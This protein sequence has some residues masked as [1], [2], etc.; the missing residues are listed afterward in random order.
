MSLP[1]PDSPDEANDQL[2][3]CLEAFIQ[4]WEDDCS[5]PDF[6]CSLRFGGSSLS[7][8]LVTMFNVR[9]IY[10]RLIQNHLPVSDDIHLLPLVEQQAW[11]YLLI[12]VTTPFLAISPLVAV[13]S[14]ARFALGTFSLIGLLGC[15]LVF[16]LY[17]KIM[18]DI[19]ALKQ[20]TFSCD[21]SRSRESAF[22]GQ[23]TTFA[24]QKGVIRSKNLYGPQNGRLID[25][26]RLV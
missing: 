5:L 3:A 26:T 25:L 2:V 12:A 13:D 18:D 20:F 17:R 1:V 10:P 24:P 6:A 4:Q 23:T 11:V 8:F 15:G 9:T 14:S 7:F 21:G 22:E 19:Q 16:W